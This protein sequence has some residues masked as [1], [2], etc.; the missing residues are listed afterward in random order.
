LEKIT[1]MSS[2]SRF[3]FKVNLTPAD[4]ES[5]VNNLNVPSTLFWDLAQPESSPSTSSERHFQKFYGDFQSDSESG[6]Y[7]KSWPSWEEFTL[8]L[9][10]EQALNSIELRK[11][12]AK[13]GAERY[14]ERSVYVCARYRTGGKKNYKRKHPEWSQ[15]VPSKSTEC[16]CSL[17]VKK[18][19]DTPVILGKYDADHNH[20]TG[21]DNLR[22]TRI[23]GTTRDWIAGMVRM[24]VK[25]NHIVTIF[26][27]NFNLL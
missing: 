27:V 19:H 10:Q 14:L 17:K 7:N 6:R 9:A 26:N 11:V 20:P 2:F 16:P 13:T 3:K 23:S 4:S 1:G 12:S 24:H 8:F 21:V 15:K 22:F 5:A 25:S 18:Y